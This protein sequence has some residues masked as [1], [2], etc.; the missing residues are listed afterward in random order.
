VLLPS[1][2]LRS[3]EQ[4]FGQQ[5][6]VKPGLVD[7][8]FLPCKQVH[9]QRPDTR[10]TQYAGYEVVPRAEATTP[11]PVSKDDKALRLRKKSKRAFE[12]D[13]VDWYLY[14]LFKMVCCHCIYS[15]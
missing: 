11:T 12:L 1:Q 3:Q 14:N 13:G 8:V 10:F 2:P 6:D 4:T 15:K 5:V 9:K 7:S